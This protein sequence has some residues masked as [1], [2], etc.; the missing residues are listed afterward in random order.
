M[1]KVE[2][3]DGAS[4]VINARRTESL[5][6]PYILQLAQPWTEKLFGRVNIVN[7]M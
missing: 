2:S 5:D 7:V 4:V 6:A 3:Q 1:A